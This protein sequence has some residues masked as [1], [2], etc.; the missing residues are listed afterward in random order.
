MHCVAG[1]L[2]I[3][4]NEHLVGKCSHCDAEQRIAA[5][6]AIRSLLDRA[7]KSL[8]AGRRLDAEEAFLAAKKIAD[9]ARLAGDEPLMFDVVGWLAVVYERMSN[10]PLAVHFQVERMQLL[11][12]K[13][14]SETKLVED[15]F[16]CGRER[17]KL[18]FYQWQLLDHTQQSDQVLAACRACLVSYS[19]VVRLIEKNG[20][21]FDDEPN[22]GHNDEQLAACRTFDEAVHVL[23]ERLVYCLAL[24]SS[25]VNAITEQ[26]TV[27]KGASPWAIEATKQ[28]AQE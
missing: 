8:D 28:D 10:W 16:E 25:I 19:A 1:Y 12:T 23:R 22:L 15:S 5:R 11:R 7:R 14:K 26:R 18:A 6:K 20:R 13:L 21:L 24:E 9:D 3:A 4:D 2:V 17:C 27:K